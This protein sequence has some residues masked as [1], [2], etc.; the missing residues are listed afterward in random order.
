MPSIIPQTVWVLDGG[1]WRIPEA[2]EQ[3]GGGILD[4]PAELGGTDASP[5]ASSWLDAWQRSRLP[6]GPAAQDPPVIGAL[7]SHGGPAGP[8]AGL[9]EGWAH[10]DI[11][12]DEAGRPHSWPLP[13]SLL[14]TEP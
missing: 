6:R 10:Q 13:L 9:A 14:S 3:V 11:R 5:S 2:S 12:G 7:Q 1:W 8:G 4:N